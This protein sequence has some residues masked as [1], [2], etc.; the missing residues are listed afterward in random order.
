MRVEGLRNL[1]CLAWLAMIIAAAI[2]I[3]TVTVIVSSRYVCAPCVPSTI[4][5]NSED[6]VVDGWCW[7]RCGFYFHFG[8]NCGFYFGFGCIYFFFL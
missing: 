5:K 3:A 2:V 4:L 7:W 6:L 1:G 8:F